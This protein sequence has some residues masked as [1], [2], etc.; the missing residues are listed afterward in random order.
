MIQKFN[1]FFYFPA[2]E[3]NELQEDNNAYEVLDK[4]VHLAFGEYLKNNNVENGDL[5]PEQT[6]KLDDLIKEI[7]KLMVEQVTINKK[8]NESMIKEGKFDPPGTPAS[9]GGNS[10]PEDN[11]KFWEGQLKGVREYLRNIQGGQKPGTYQ[12]TT[13]MKEAFDDIKQYEAAIEY[14]KTYIK[15][16]GE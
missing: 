5:S 8:M 11:L 4:Y 10:T 3:G 6:I 15:K 9:L 14:T 7:S 1:E 13:E 12:T 2:E 16:M